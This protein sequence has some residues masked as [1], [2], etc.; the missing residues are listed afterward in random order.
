MYVCMYNV[1]GQLKFRSEALHHA[2]THPISTTKLM[3]I[4]IYTCIY[5]VHCTYIQMYFPYDATTHPYTHTHT[6]SNV[7]T[8]IHI[9]IHTCKRAHTYTYTHVH[10]HI[11]IHTQTHTQTYPPHTHT[12]RA[13]QFWSR[14]IFIQNFG[15]D[16]LDY[17]I[18]ISQ[19]DDQTKQLVGSDHSVTWQ[20]RKQ[21]CLYAGDRQGAKGAGQHGGPNEPLIDGV[22]TDYIVDGPFDTSFAYSQFGQ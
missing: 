20:R 3:Y 22:Y 8:C 17:L 18:E 21:R 10:T 13:G 9:C 5:A 11:H 7:Y 4:R 16:P 14:L 6:Y 19:S 2:K 1:C 15:I 12:H